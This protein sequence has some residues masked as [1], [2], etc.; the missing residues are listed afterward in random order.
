MLQEKNNSA[1]TLRRR[2]RQTG[3]DLLLAVLMTGGS[4]VPLLQIWGSLTP[5][6]LWPALAALAAVVIAL[7]AVRLR[8][9]SLKLSV[10]VCLAPWLVLLPVLGVGRIWQ[11]LLLWLNCGISL[12]NALHQGGLSLLAASATAESVLAF[13]VAV[14]FLQGQVCLLCAAR[15]RLVVAC[16]WVTAL[17]TVQLL[18]GTF[19]PLACAA[20]I[21]ALLGAWCSRPGAM[22]VRQSLRVW[23]LCAAAML[24]C[25]VILPG[26]ELAQVSQA[27]KNMA[28]A[29]HVARY[30]EDQLPMGDL[31]KAAQLHAGDTEVMTV[32][33]EQEK[34]LY[35][36][37]FVGADYS[38]GVWTPLPDSAYAGEYAGMLKWLQAQGFDP[39]TQP[40]A[41]QRLTDSENEP[42]RNRVYLNVSGGSRAYLY[43]PSSV[44]IVSGTQT[45]DVKDTRMAPQGLLGAR[46]YTVTELPSAYPAELTVRASWVAEPQT[47]EQE[48]YAQAEAVYR[49]FVF[50]N[51]TAVDKELAPVLQE[52]FWADAQ[53]DGDSIYSA[54]NRVRQVLSQR[55]ETASDGTLSADVLDLLTGTGRGNAVLYASAAVQ[56]LRSRGIP[57]RYVEGYYVSADMARSSASQAVT[58]TAQNAHAWAEVYFDGIGWLPVDV[59]PGYYF[60]AVTLQQMVALPDATHK[61][62]AIDDA[63]RDSSQAEGGGTTGKS[64]LQETVMGLKQLLLVLAGLL[65]CLL[66][67]A[68]VLF[69]AAEMLRYLAIRLEDRAIRRAAPRQKTRLLCRKL[70]RILSACGIDACLGWST[71]Q[72]DWA[73]AI[74]FPLVQP[75]EYTRVASLLE[76]FLFGGQELQPHELR[77]IYALLEKVESGGK[78]NLSARLK[79][80][81]SPLVYLRRSFRKEQPA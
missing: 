23:G 56:A 69:L 71:G 12:W 62:A 38:G 53:E 33:A 16:V 14:A 21:I 28:Q 20:C 36:R 81:Y 3:W 65:S 24:L 55:T 18:T 60:D 54:V 4:L 49:E 67:L 30:G 51:Y 61:T 34:S 72:T 5:G 39:L 8:S 35:L 74:T 57:A 42:E 44:E 75:G 22:P 66:V 59:T 64:P 40:A 29:V 2:L 77:T 50:R 6:L 47:Q 76:K 73:V 7:A 80:R 43:A 13:S 68:T 41:Y 9:K 52:L 70:L 63:E 78:N 11:G 15:R 46:I 37:G 31:S 79:R 10:V 17:L 19:L 58:L 25:A 48:R 1:D 32:R 27:R 26:G 45:K